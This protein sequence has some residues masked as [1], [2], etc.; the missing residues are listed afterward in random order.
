MRP[1][2]LLMALLAAACVRKVANG[3][4]CAETRACGNGADCYRGVCTP[5]CADDG[6]CDGELVCARHHCLLATGEPRRSGEAAT[7]GRSQ[8]AD[9]R[10]PTADGRLPNADGRS[11]NADGRAPMA[12]G[13]LPNADS[14]VPTADGRLPNADSRVPTADGRLP[15]ADD[16]PI[17]PGLRRGA[18]AN[19]PPDT[20]ALASELRAIRVE[21]ENLRKEQQ[22][23]NDA[24]DA[25][26]SRR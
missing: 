5:L 3:E 22:R 12:D 23:L 24:I 18:S 13:R 6:E 11:P 20:A 7:D 4:A 26:K 15:N 25:L 21:L 10:V 2:L 9:S 16:L 19:P 1:T 14:R 17:R 8:N